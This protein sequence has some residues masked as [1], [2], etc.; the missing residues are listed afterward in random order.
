MLCAYDHLGLGAEMC[1]LKGQIIDSTSR[2]FSPMIDME[3]M[4]Q[5]LR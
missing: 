5:H 3:R 1:S 2:V 4:N